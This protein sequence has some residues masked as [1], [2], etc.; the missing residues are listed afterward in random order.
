M[1]TVGKQKQQLVAQV[2]RV[3][4]GGGQRLSI[5]SSSARTAAALTVGETYEVVAKVDCWI[6]V[7][8]SSVD[9]VAGSDRFLP[10][11]Q[12][13]QTTIETGLDYLAVIRDASDS[14]NG[15]SICRVS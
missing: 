14:T 10:A 2:S 13:I 9:A 4:D 1:G 5:G 12:P 6:V 3:V 7:G 11:Y 8:G 15:L